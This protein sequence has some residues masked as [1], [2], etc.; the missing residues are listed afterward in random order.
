V[1]D[2]VYNSGSLV[3]TNPLELHV[4]IAAGQSLT[5]TQDVP[6]GFYSSIGTFTITHV[7]LGAVNP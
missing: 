7:A 4:A 1:G 5:L 6:V 2:T 3:E